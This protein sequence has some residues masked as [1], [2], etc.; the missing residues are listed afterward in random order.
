MRVVAIAHM[1]SAARV[2]DRPRRSA[3][4]R[5]G[6]IAHWAGWTSAK[7][8]LRFEG[9]E[10]GYAELERDA[11]LLAGWLRANGTAA[12]DRV[13]YLGPNCPE[14]LELLFKPHDELDEVPVAFVVPVAGSALSADRVLALF[15]GRL[16]GYKHPREVLFVNALPRNRIGKID[17]SALRELVA[18]ASDEPRAGV[19]S[20]PQPGS[21]PRPAARQRCVSPAGPRVEPLVTAPA[22]VP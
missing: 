16:A 21:R 13:G 19:E 5:A 12:G 4:L 14:L 15:H 1:T 8:A 17:R 9:R 18:S 11:G 20:T 22:S 10:I 2:S 7:P 6:W 3:L